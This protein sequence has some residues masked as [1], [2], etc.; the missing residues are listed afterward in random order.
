MGALAAAALDDPS[1]KKTTETCCV[2][3]RRY[4]R[5]SLIETFEKKIPEWDGEERTG[6]L[7][8]RSF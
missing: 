7:P 6:T 4:R 5:N 2:W 1:I 8:D 3:A